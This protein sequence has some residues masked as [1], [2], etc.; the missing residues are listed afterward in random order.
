MF[1]SNV[2]W[3][4][5]RAMVLLALAV[6]ACASGCSKSTDR[7]VHVRIA[8]LLHGQGS[9]VP[10]STAHYPRAELGGESRVITAPV[11]P[12]TTPW[13]TRQHGSVR[14][15]VPSGS[16][17]A[18]GYGVR[19]GAADSFAAPV[20]FTLRVTRGDRSE[21]VM[22]ETVRPE[23]TEIN[24][25][26]DASV[27]LGAWEGRVTFDL[28]SSSGASGLD[29]AT[30]QSIAQAYFSA[31]ILS[32]P[33]AY[34]QRRNLLLISLDTL[35]A[36][37]LGIYGY[38][39]PT[40]PNIDRIFRE[41]GT[42]IEQFYSNAA[43][44]LLGHTA[45]LYGLL[46]CQGLV[47][48]HARSNHPPWALSL[49]EV[50]ASAGYRTA[51]FTENA[52]LAGAFGFDR[53]FDRYVEE[54]EIE[55]SGA[56]AERGMALGH[57][58]RTFSR[59]LQ[60][61]ESNHERPFFLFLHTYQVHG[62]Y[63]PPTQYVRRLP[64]PPDADQAARDSAAYDAEIAYTDEQVG[65]LI[66]RLAELRLDRN[67]L[68]VVT[69]DHGE[70][71]G[72]HGRRL[73]GTALHDEIVQIPLLLRGPDIVS[74]GVRRTGRVSLVD[75]MPTLLD[76]VEVKLPSGLFGR[77]FAE[78]LHEGGR[79][80]RARIFAE[81]D[82]KVAFTYAGVDEAWVRPSFSVTDWPLRLIRIG[83]PDGARFEL[84]DLEADPAERHDLY[85]T[86][87]AEVTAL[88]ATL[89]SYEEDC[90]RERERLA[91]ELAGG[92]AAPGPER[93]IDPAQREKLRALGY[94]D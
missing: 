83:T 42:V 52:Y 49:G 80:L 30:G 45:M 74:A 54:K 51:A 56:T 63:T 23:P 25:W 35:R 20:D 34:E 66:D 48:D 69:A 3:L 85:P 46:P 77:S 90:Q 17:L 88:R 93:A 22:R 39:K 44:T 76:L 79:P 28:L 61:L 31:P 55:V 24:V 78:N 7:R 41:E 67:T 9:V 92:K 58:E 2:D 10:G 40:S 50:L 89:D 4:R 21:L 82:G 27:D 29:P 1:K 37:R 68:V 12:G 94:L 36:D 15:D 59:G 71:F 57:I 19:A 33:A 64:E 84:Y 91:V 38:D 73:H 8:D 32:G 72:E 14:V 43:D 26:H 11:L 47:V 5:L 65:H 16:R 13:L 87:A 60:W 62:P 75:L 6:V 81:A 70:E 53:G 18:V 86:R